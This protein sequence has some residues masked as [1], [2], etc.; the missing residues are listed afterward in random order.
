[1]NSSLP[2]FG[3]SVRNSLITTPVVPPPPAAVVATPVS[4]TSAPTPLMLVVMFSEPVLVPAGVTGV[5]V[6][7]TEVAAPGSS[8]V[9]AGEITVYW[10]DP[11]RNGG[12]S[13]IDERLLLV[14]VID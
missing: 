14:I 7:D 4:G 8:V 3:P 6:T 10:D 1:M 5:N 13:V 9:A 12:V 11:V 2:P